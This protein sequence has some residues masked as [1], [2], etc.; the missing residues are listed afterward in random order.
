MEN[1]NNSKITYK[2]EQGTSQTEKRD[3]KLSSEIATAKDDVCGVTGLEIVKDEDSGE[4]FNQD[5]FND[6]VRAESKFTLDERGAIKELLSSGTYSST[7]ELASRLDKPGTISKTAPENETRERRAAYKI[8]QLAKHALSDKIKARIVEKT[9]NWQPTRQGEKTM[10]NMYAEMIGSGNPTF[11]IIDKLCDTRL[12]KQVSTDSWVDLL[13]ARDAEISEELTKW[14]ARSGKYFEEAFDDVCAR[15]E[16]NMAPD[17]E[18]VASS[19]TSINKPARL[20]F[21]KRCKEFVEAEAPMVARIAALGASD[22]HPDV[23][24]DTKWLL[25][26]WQEKWQEKY[27]VMFQDRELKSNVASFRRR[28]FKSLVN[29]MRDA[30]LAKFKREGVKYRLNSPSL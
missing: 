17:A 14:E 10:Q 24:M 21:E 15:L 8:S 4:L 26:E 22:L 30:E 16:I 11:K 29:K 3:P 28:H 2:T 20:E 23:I 5:Q 18:K 19:F 1:S 7:I 25:E 6:S 9:E 13:K 27:A 12:N